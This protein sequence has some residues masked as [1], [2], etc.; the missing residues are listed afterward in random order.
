MCL[1]LPEGK[2]SVQKLAGKF[3]PSGYERAEKQSGRGATCRACEL[4]AVRAGELTCMKTEEGDGSDCSSPVQFLSS[5]PSEQ[6]R[7]PSQRS[8]ASRQASPSSQR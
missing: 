5:L 1:K 7:Y 3:V 4:K 6:S 8:V 2:I